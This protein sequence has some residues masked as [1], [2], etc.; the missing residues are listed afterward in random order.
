LTA[1]WALLDIWMEAASSLIGLLV[2]I[3]ALKAYRIMRERSLL[4]LNTSF[5]VIGSG[6]LTR[7][8]VLLYLAFTQRLQLRFLLQAANLIYLLSTLLGYLMLA[9]AYTGR[10]W[11]KAAIAAQLVSLLEISRPLL[12]FDLIDI[13]L[14]IYVCANLV[15]SYLAQ[16]SGVQ[17]SVLAGFLLI[18]SSHAMPLLAT[19]YPPLLL[20]EAAI[21]LA[22]FLSLFLA[23][24]TVALRR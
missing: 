6:M 15:S 2:G 14:L 13:F 7:V 5:L 8:L 3:Y 16:R 19:I 21:R 23:L 12:F 22:G 10:D 1:V 9:L 18:L 11:G 24:A 4:Y 17:L 20:L